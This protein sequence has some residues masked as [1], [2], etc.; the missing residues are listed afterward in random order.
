MKIKMKRSAHRRIRSVEG[1]SLGLV[2]R[3]VGG[4]K[5]LSGLLFSKDDGAFVK[6]R[7]KVL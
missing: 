6:D 4:Q 2:I 1:C 5:R 3:K 7:C